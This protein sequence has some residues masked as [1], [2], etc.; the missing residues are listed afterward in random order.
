MEEKKLSKGRPKQ[1]NTYFAA[2]VPIEFAELIRKA[3][4]DSP[5]IGIRIL[6]NEIK[7]DVKLLKKLRRE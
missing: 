2:S 4:C 1:E 6:W 5:S 7:N 3:G